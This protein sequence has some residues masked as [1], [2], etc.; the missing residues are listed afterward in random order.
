MKLIVSKKELKALKNLTEIIEDI[1]GVSTDINLSDKILV[2][3]KSFIIGIFTG[4]Y[5]I[6]LREEFVSDYINLI[7]KFVS[8]ASP[9]LKTLHSTAMQL[10]PIVS[11]FK[12]EVAEFIAK[13]DE[14]TEEESS[15]NAVSSEIEREVI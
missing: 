3:K 11:N 8:I 12:P 13:Y 14:R 7:T 6:E 15:C 9:V 2:S 5:V 10:A 1:E 4:E